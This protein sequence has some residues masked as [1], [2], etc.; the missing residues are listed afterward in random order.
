MARADEKDVAT[1]PLY[2]FG[3]TGSDDV[4]ADGPQHSGSDDQNCTDES[5]YYEEPGFDEDER[6]F[7][8]DVWMD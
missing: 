4:A 3:G 8:I 7:L 6:R 2:H 5:S 1:I